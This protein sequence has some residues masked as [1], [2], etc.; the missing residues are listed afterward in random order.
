MKHAWKLSRFAAAALTAA[1]V[2]TSGVLAAGGV[3]TAVGRHFPAKAGI[4]QVEKPAAEPVTPAEEAAITEEAASTDPADSTDPAAS[5]EETA[6]PAE[7]P[8]D[9]TESETAEE[10]AAPA[11]ETPVQ[12]GPYIQPDAQ[13]AE[14]W[15]L[16]L[17][18]P[19]NDLPEDYTMELVTLSNGLKVDQRIYADLDAML[20][21]CREAGLNPVVCSAYRTEA[22][23]TRLY[24]NKIA[25][26]RS[27]GWTGEAL[28]TEAARWV[29]PP[30]TS[31]H[32]TGLALDI[33]SAR[34]QSLT[35]AQEDTAEQQWLMEH[36]WEYGFILRYPEDKTE[37][38][39]IGYEP[40]H[41]R[42]V[43][44]ETA[45]AIHESGLCLEEYLQTLPVSPAE[46]PAGED[47]LAETAAETE[48]AP[49]E[50]APA[51]AEAPA[52]G[53]AETAPETE[54]AEEAPGMEPAAETD[55]AP[56][57]RS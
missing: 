42:Y 12:T 56:E 30:G 18:N 46:V 25:R 49:E 11:E 44:R 53:T 23:Q 4:T 1:F 41:Y 55:T 57:Q 31:E 47:A 21:A 5:T 45:A 52:E 14:D 2:L 27:A 10:P 20:S 7:G 38:T 3:V 50:T 43:G 34:Y 33:V 54:A 26:L 13:A 29:A 28:L 35:E 15:R 48:P 16:L 9:G 17:V 24:N 6:L 8:A 37:I 39:G 36:C 19:W 32:Q 22:T 40:W 51:E